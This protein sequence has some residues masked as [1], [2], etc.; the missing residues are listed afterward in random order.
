M[1]HLATVLT[2]LGRHEEAAATARRGLALEPADS[3][4][5]AGLAAALKAA[6]ERTGERTGE[7]ARERI[8][9]LIGAYQAAIAAKP[10]V[11]D[12]AVALAELHL[13]RG[14]S[15]ASLE[16]VEECLARLPRDVWCLALKC[17]LLNELGDHDG[18]GR[19]ADFDRLIQVKRWDAVP[20]FGQV[21]R[22]NAALA[23]HVLGH[24]SLIYQ[25]DKATR[26][27]RHS[28]NLLV[29][30]KGPM[31]A[32]ELMIHELVET[33]VQSVGRHDGN[34]LLADPP[35][36]WCLSIWAV[37]MEGQGY[38]IPHVHPSAWLSGVYYPTVPGAARAKAGGG[39]EE[40]AGWLEFGRPFLRHRTRAE[41]RL[42]T[43][44]PV[45]GLM[46]LF[47]PYFL[48]STVPFE[49]QETRISIAFDVLPVA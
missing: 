10:G 19:L 5:L 29:P 38:Q 13:E 21:A 46:V 16:V 35:E 12:A 24:P 47:P 48:H 4:A 45:E 33:Y 7:R 6:P 43:I 31:G 20:E 14:D 9:E 34:H 23:E 1:G 25:P 49:S 41:P 32:L 44:R 22:L 11:S 27:G 40:E 17:T 42:M 30:P 36:R 2:A 15:G 39:S 37:V 3:E 18:L 26:Q 28:G 8:G